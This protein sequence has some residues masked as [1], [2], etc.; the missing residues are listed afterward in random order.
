MSSVAITMAAAPAV[1]GLGASP[2]LLVLLAGLVAYNAYEMATSCARAELDAARS[3]AERE[4]RRLR[5]KEEGKKSLLLLCGR[6]TQ[7]MTALIDALS[8]EKERNVLQSQLNALSSRFRADIEGGREDVPEAEFR[9]IRQRILSIQMDEKLAC[10]LDEELGKIESVLSGEGGEMPAGFRSEWDEI[11]GE[12]Q[13][14]KALA[15]QERIKSLTALLDRA[16][17][18]AE[19]A[20]VA[21][22]ISLAGLV[23]EKYTLPAR[24][25]TPE[26]AKLASLLSDI[27]DFGARVAFY[28]DG[29]AR[30]I[31]PLLDE[32][33]SD[34][35]RADE[36]RLAAI[37]EEVRMRYGKLKERTVQTE[38]F[39]EELR[40]MLPL[41]RRARGAEA[42]I[43][44]M[45]ELLTAREISHAVYTPL[46]RDVKAFLAEQLEGIVDDVLAEKVGATLEEMGYSLVGGE[47]DD[48][49]AGEV[50]F[51]QSPYD[52]Y[53]VKVKVD[54]G[55]ML[56]TRLVRVVESEDEK[57]ATSEY[58]RQKD[59]EVG[60]KWC[61]DL[62]AFHEKMKS[63]GV[64]FETALRKEPEELPL[65]VVVEARAGGGKKKTQATREN[66]R[67]A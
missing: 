31:R 39:K 28:D 43:V 36:Y 14:T 67:Q 60:R 46:Y 32:A 19:K 42:L 17:T 16:R 61:R 9:E 23:E 54:E 25:P 59:I 27:L 50:N 49:S 52:G 13:K 2:L 53:R 56:S 58:Q 15:L 41:V 65:D 34:E 6:I 33:A 45:E 10:M 37:R 30:K 44:R 26:G 12:R 63:A 11:R 24:I 57:N 38:T 64:E 35:T 18:F 5:M 1:V 22:N 40:D 62:D 55:G 3:E 66:A 4:E 8:D 47:G 7:E 51:V 48:L 20:A 29:E 21:A